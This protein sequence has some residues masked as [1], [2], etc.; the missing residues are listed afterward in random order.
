MNDYLYFSKTTQFMSSIF[1][2]D[3][4]GFERQFIVVC[5]VASI[6]VHPLLVRWNVCRTL[7]S[8]SGVGIPRARRIQQRLILFFRHTFGFT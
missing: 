1:F 6:D 7:V 4:L 5:S 8:I 3:F 2:G